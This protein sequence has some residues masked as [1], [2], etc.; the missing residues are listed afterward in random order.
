M[1]DNDDDDD[2][3]CQLPVTGGGDLQIIN[4]SED[5]REVD[6]ASQRKMR[7]KNRDFQNSESASGFNIS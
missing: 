3:C 4:K 1:T 6:R 5:P 7:H 2:I